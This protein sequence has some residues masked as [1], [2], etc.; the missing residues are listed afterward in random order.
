MTRVVVRDYEPEDYFVIDAQEFTR[1]NLTEDQKISTSVTHKFAG[2]HQTIL[3]PE[4]DIIACIGI[5]RMW[6][7]TGEVWGLFSPL[8]KKYPMAWFAVKKLLKFYQKNDGY[9]R[10]QATARC[11]WPEA[12][13]LM[14]HLGFHIEGKLEAYGPWGADS[15]MYALVERS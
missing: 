15:M 13:R 9:R 6:D 8:M 12:M 2:P 7:G 14:D 1:G 5:H 3:T 11:D 4:G 10:L